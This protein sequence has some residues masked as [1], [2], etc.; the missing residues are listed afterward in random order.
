MMKRQYIT[1]DTDVI[2]M[3]LEQQ[4]CTLSNDGLQYNL[5]STPGNEIESEESLL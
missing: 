2:V 1:P 4:L 3:H 5:D